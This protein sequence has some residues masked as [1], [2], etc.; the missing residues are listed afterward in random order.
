MASTK[1]SLHASRSVQTNLT[2]KKS[3]AK[4]PAKTR[5]LNIS[6]EGSGGVVAGGILWRV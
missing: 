6:A 1:N 2:L 4:P 3:A 5:V